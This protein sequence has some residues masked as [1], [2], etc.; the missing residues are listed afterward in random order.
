[1]NTQKGNAVPEMAA[2]KIFTCTLC[3]NKRHVVLF[4]KKGFPIVRCTNCDL[5]ST[6]LPENFNTLDI[7]D[8]GYFQGGQEDGYA[9]YQ[10]SEKILRAEFR[11]VLKK[12]LTYFKETGGKK[13]LEIGSAYGYFLDE[14]SAY[15]DCYGIEVNKEG[16]EQS[17]K[18]GLKVFEEL[19]ENVTGRIGKVD[20]VVMLDVIEHLNNPLQTVSQLYEMMNPG[21]IILIVTGNHNSLLSKIM[22]QNWRL[23]TP[24]QHTFFF[25]EKTLKALVAR[26]GFNILSADS[27][28]KTVPL[29]LPFY[30]VGSRIGFRIKSLE[31]ISSVGI[32]LNLFDTTRIIARK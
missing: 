2:E 18:R 10:S 6:V 3:G 13:L 8:E 22:K 21:G 20:A 16:V 7:Y 17:N 32:P 5:V 19:N 26:A 27:P 12:L 31:N 15:F 28:W 9:D 29:G 11:S 24:P 25:S 30:Q 23:M 1:M 14:A 4:E